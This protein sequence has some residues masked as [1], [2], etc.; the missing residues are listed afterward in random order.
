MS[1]E[2]PKSTFTSK[3]S[4]LF[5]Q[6][7]FRYIIFILNCSY[8]NLE[9]YWNDNYNSFPDHLVNILVSHSGILIFF[10]FKI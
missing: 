2:F 9:E 6:Y 10:L 4:K 3:T 7:L 8:Y 1:L 5:F